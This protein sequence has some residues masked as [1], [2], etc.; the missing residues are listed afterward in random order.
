M[1]L[2]RKSQRP[3]RGTRKKQEPYAREKRGF[4]LK[5]S[6][7]YF[8]TFTGRKNGRGPDSKGKEGTKCRIDISPTK[9]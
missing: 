3:E 9:G 5:V 4:K 1:R 2:E 8:G 7:K 6:L